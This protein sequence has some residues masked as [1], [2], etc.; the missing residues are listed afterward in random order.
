[1]HQKYKN[2]NFYLKR[3]T[4]SSLQNEFSTQGCPL[5]QDSP[6]SAAFGITQLPSRAMYGDGHIQI[7]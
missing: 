3:Y 7:F 4:C 2:E 1:M 6:A 5:A